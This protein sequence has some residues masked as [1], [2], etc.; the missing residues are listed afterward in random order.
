[1]NLKRYIK[2]ILTALL[3][4]GVYISIV[5][6]NATADIHHEIAIET[7]VEAEQSKPQLIVDDLVVNIISFSSALSRELPSSQVDYVLF[8]YKEEIFRPP[9]AT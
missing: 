7:V 3:L 1:M 6:I 8:S 9:L 5:E 2:T 4:L